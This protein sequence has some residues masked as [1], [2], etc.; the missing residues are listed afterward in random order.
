LRCRRR[1]RR[2]RRCILR[3]GYG[4]SETEKGNKQEWAHEFDRGDALDK[5]KGAPMNCN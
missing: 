2:N 1:R 3:H 5:S 4:G